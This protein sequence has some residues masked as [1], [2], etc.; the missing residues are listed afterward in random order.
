MLLPS[1]LALFLGMEADWPLTARFDE[2]RLSNST[3]D[4]VCASGEHERPTASTSISFW[5]APVASTRTD[6]AV[7]PFPSKLPRFSLGRG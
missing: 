1:S 4:L 6:Q 2:H 5:C 7:P 3:M